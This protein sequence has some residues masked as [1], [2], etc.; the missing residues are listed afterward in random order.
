MA[1][2]RV[3]NTTITF[4]RFIKFLLPSI[5]DQSL[6]RKGER[7]L[8]YGFSSIKSSCTNSKPASLAITSARGSG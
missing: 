2:G 4:F 1:S 7:I 5:S 3:P 6:D 8:V